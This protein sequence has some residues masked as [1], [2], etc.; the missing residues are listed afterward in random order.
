MFL[1]ITFSAN[2]KIFESEVIYHKIFFQQPESLRFE[3]E[4][5]FEDVEDQLNL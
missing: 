4:N 2:N 3:M 1:Q 5:K